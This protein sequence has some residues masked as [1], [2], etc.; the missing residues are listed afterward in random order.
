MKELSRTAKTT[1]LGSLSIS[2]FLDPLVSQGLI[3]LQ[4][5]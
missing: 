5:E 2:N 3:E 4:C 1:D